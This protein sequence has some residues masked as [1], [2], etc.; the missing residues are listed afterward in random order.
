MPWHGVGSFARN[1]IPLRTIMKRLLERQ[2]QV[3][4]SIISQWSNDKPKK[5]MRQRS[6]LVCMKI[7]QV[8][9]CLQITGDSSFYIPVKVKSWKCMRKKT[10]VFS[11]RSHLVSSAKRPLVIILSKWHTDRSVACDQLP[12]RLRLV[13][14][15]IPGSVA[16]SVSTIRGLITHAN[17]VTLLGRTAR[18]E[19]MPQ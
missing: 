12:V 5:Y 8:G 13:T 10:S 17:G 14:S 19:F 11:I 3:N 9:V 16:R 2:T 6:Q 1:I 7:C 15:R 4:N 18:L